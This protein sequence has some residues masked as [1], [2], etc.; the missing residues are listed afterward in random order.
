MRFDGSARVKQL[1]GACGAIVWRLPVWN[2]LEAAFK[3]LDT[4]TVDEAEYEGMLM[5]SDL[6]YPW[7][8][9]D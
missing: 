5:G 2:I 1:G 6:F 8:G 7:K 4:S 9:E 3:Y